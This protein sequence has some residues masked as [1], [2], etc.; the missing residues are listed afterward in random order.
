VLVV[1]T[2]N[3]QEAI[4][5]TDRELEDDIRAELEW[6]PKIPDPREIAVAARLGHV[7]LRGTVSGLHQRR[8]AAAAAKRVDG[9]F[10]LDD[11]L[12]VRIMDGLARDDADVRGAA[13]QA[14]QWN[15]QVPAASI[16]VAVDVGHVTLTGHV[17]WPYQKQAAEETVAAM[18]GVTDVRNEI[19][20][21]G[22]MMEVATLADD[23]GAA[24]RRSAQADAN[25]IAIHVHDGGV[26]LEGKVTSWAEHDAAIAAASA[27]PGVRIVHDHLLVRD[28]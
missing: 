17:D 4:M 12:K 5:K 11:Q 8:A 18:V 28:P 27:A 25:R 20:V 13:L 6:D 2:T 22:T 26:T 19:A 7:T 10:D 3:N 14:L 24:L 1:N 15:A 16:D 21:A 9:T 23:I